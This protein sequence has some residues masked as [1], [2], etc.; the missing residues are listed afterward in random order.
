MAGLALSQTSSNKYLHIC[1]KDDLKLRLIKQ[2]VKVVNVS[3]S[4]S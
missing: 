1:V 4:L 3:P 2:V